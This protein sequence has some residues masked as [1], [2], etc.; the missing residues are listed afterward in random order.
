MSTDTQSNQDGQY[1]Q[2]GSSVVLDVDQIFMMWMGV[3]DVDLMFMV[4]ILYF[5]L[6][7][8]QC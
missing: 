8:P 4:W 3:A 5:L 7:N 2:M 6:S 1:G